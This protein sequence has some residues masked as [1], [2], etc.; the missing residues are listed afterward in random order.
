MGTRAMNVHNTIARLLAWSCL[1]WSSLTLAAAE[2][3]SEF[4][5]VE[6]GRFKLGDED[7]YFVGSNFYR[8]ALA[9][10]FSGQD[11]RVVDAEGKARYPLV[12]EVFAGYARK[13]VKV[14]RLWGFA[15]EGSRGHSIQPA[16][17]T[18]SGLATTPVQLNEEGFER[19]D[20]VI[21]AAGTH[22]VKLILP[23]VNFEHEYC[24]MEW[25]VENTVGSM[26][27]HLFYT[28]P[29]VWEKFTSYVEQVLE[30]KN[31]Y[32]QRAYKDDPAIM[33]IE[34]ANEPHTKDYYECTRTGL[35]EGEC[36]SRNMKDFGSGSL[37]FDWL[38]RITA[39]VKKVDS[40]HLVANGEEGYLAS[41]DSLDP[42]CRDKHLW[43]HNGSK[44]TDYERNAALPTIDF[45]TTH[46]YP[47]N[48]NIPI[49]ELPWVQRCIIEHRAQIARKLGKPI[50][51]EE[52][53]FNERPEAYGQKEYK[54]DRPYYISRMFRMATEAGY[55][56]TMV[57]QAM[58]LLSN[59]RPADDDDFTFP[60]YQTVDG[61]D[62]ITPEGYAVTLQIACMNQF[63]PKGL[64]SSC[65]TVCPKGTQV[66]GGRLGVDPEGYR[67]YL[68]EALP[69]PPTPFPVCDN[70]SAQANGWGWSKTEA[71]CLAHPEAALQFPKFGG[72]SCTR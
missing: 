8:L 34:V 37:V 51:L 58:P 28:D 1:S 21:A 41:P 71:L 52:T 2:P 57:W 50:V 30:R 47:D 44:G 4:V 18:K 33:A 67:C 25:W 65:I 38:E 14:V 23:L 49:S 69:V 53:G 43:I 17:M 27:K 56:G 15:C 6:D 54:L 46:I 16:L 5:R 10:R 36:M 66:D 31:P 63:V 20:Y 13:G 19:L 64:Q 42:S 55:A 62:R 9:D 72:C 39:F 12:D 32:T 48:W 7:F 59:G 68:P 11:Q 60:I 3:K 35:S 70:D 61:R 29:K 22:G 26:N 40:N 24:G 45:L